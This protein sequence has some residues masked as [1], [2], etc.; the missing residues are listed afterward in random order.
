[1]FAAVLAALT[2]AASA[3]AQ[4]KLPSDEAELSSNDAGQLESKARRYYQ[5]GLYAK[6]ESLLRRVL[7]IQLNLQ[8]PEHSDVAT[9]LHNLASLYQTTG[10]DS[11]AETLY[12]LALALRERAL[13][14]DHSDVALSLNGLA[15]LLQ[16]KGEYELAVSLYWH[17][18]TVLGKTLGPDHPDVA[19]ILNNLASLREATGDYVA[20]EALYRRALAIDEKALGVEHPHVAISLT[21]LG[22]L[23]QAK[24]D[25]DTAESFFHR[26]LAILEGVLGPVHPHVATSLNSLALLLKAKWE[27][28]AAE[29]LFRRALD[30][31]QKMLGPEHP[32]VATSLHNLASL[33]QAMGRDS[34]AETLYRRALRIREK[35]LGPEHPDVAMS[36]NDLGELVQEKGDYGTAESL[37]RRAL[38]VR[39]KMLGPEHP[40][41]ATSLNSLALLLKARGDYH[42]AE[43][44]FRRALDIRQKLFGAE[45]PHVAT[46]L[47]NLASLYKAMGYHT[48]AET[49]YRLALYIREKALGAEHPHVAVSLNGLASLFEVT[50]RLSDA[51]RLRVRAADIQERQVTLLLANGLGEAARALLDDFSEEFHAYVS[52]EQVQFLHAGLADRTAAARL[53]LLT[54]L[55]HKGRA[56]DAW[57]DP[58]L[59]RLGI[60]TDQLSALTRLRSQLVVRL[61]SGPRLGESLDHHKKMIGYLRQTILVT[62]VGLGI[63]QPHISLEAV[64]AAIP[65]GSVLVEFVSYQPVYQRTGRGRVHRPRRY[66]CYVLSR[67]GTVEHVELGEVAPI[68]NLIAELRRAIEGETG[69]GSLE[70]LARQLDNMI[71]EPV[72]PLLGDSRDILL[73]P[74]GGLNLLPF[75]ALRDEQGRYLIERFRI[76]YLT[77]GRDL[78]RSR[79]RTA[80]RS[81]P[82]LVLGGDGRHDNLLTAREI[83]NAD[84]EGTQIVVLSASA[85]A[86]GG[87]KPG[88]GIYALRRALVLSGAETQVLSLWRAPAERTAQLLADFYRR[89]HSGQGRSEA[90]RQAQLAMLADKR[91]AHPFH[92]AGFISQG[93]GGTLGGQPPNAVRPVGRGFHGC[94]C[95]LPRTADASGSGWRA[96]LLL[97]AGAVRRIGGQRATSS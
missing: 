67:S 51:L 91:T 25:Y 46:S 90:L 50:G 55:R 95:H 44:L 49:R 52:L 33:Y 82:V 71:M 79:T 4:Q 87:A 76:N 41:V 85:T 56:L 10:Y 53:A 73:S 94:A 64:R 78:L 39:E 86:V 18:I 70:R 93:D 61:L 28:R 66:A 60:A 23:I 69:G 22:G 38:A 27:Y 74:D 63:A 32:H 6:A 96:V 34:E 8:G 57:R 17:A 36:L 9:T 48:A 88:E 35:A 3:G 13:G 26:A 68:D 11:Q 89:V 14:A 54:I 59:H 72:R 58:R 65:A 29:P 21:N 1:L 37:F 24:G 97:V 20:A 43:P 42:Q 92:W 47:H 81:G 31:R 7:A 62:A 19:T 83:A 77:S 40:D 15:L 12:R 5:Q 80:P 75:A 84:L 16:G 2:L 30:I 45:H